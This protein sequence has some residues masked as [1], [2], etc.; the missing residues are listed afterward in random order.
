MPPQAYLYA[1]PYRLYDQ[2]YVR[3]YGFQG[4][5]HHY[6]ALR[7]AATLRDEGIAGIILLGDP[8]AAGLAAALLPGL[9]AADEA[10]C[11]PGG[12]PA[13]DGER[14]YCGEHRLYEDECGICQPQR[15]AL[16]APRESM[17]V[18]LA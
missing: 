18:R 5:A 10:C 15:A 3:R 14:A 8:A 4:I 12:S 6:V 2:G 1:L 11:P 7:A 17:K 9:A 13:A 16:P